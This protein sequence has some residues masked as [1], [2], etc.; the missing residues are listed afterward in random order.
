MKRTREPA[1]S[2]AI[3]KTKTNDKSYRSKAFILG[4]AFDLG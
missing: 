4:F 1:I 3:G 2:I